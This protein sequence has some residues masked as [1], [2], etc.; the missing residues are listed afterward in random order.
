M[1]KSVTGFDWDSG[2][3]MKCQ[4][5]G[6]TIEVIEDLFGSDEL[7]IQPDISNSTDEIRYRA[8]GKNK[9]NRAVF[10]VFTFR[11]RGGERFIRP[12]S[13]RYMHRKEYDD[14]EKEI[15]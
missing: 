13:A 5:H 3:L 10:L 4:K 2:N 11:V 14:Y 12:I 8:V 6:V 1:T 15:S 7:R 9:Q